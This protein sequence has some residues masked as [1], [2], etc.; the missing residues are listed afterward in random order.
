MVTVT[1]S[2]LE[3]LTDKTRDG[4][5]SR[6]DA[7]ALGTGTNESTTAT[8][9]GN[10][11]HR[12][13]DSEPA[14]S[15]VETDQTTYEAR[16]TVTGG[17]EVPAGTAISEIAVLAGGAGGGGTLVVIDQFDAVT[18]EAG[19]TERFDVPLEFTR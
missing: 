19:H 11:V 17:T 5:S 1:D 18:V 2:G 8:A 14:V 12:G 7:V 15:F 3:W 9:L 16:I 4:A 6:V 13:D 10:E